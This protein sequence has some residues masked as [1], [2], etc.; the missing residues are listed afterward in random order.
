MHLHGGGGGVRGEYDFGQKSIRLNLL[1]LIIYNIKPNNYR[2]TVLYFFIQSIRNNFC[3]KLL[4][5][6]ECFRIHR[7]RPHTLQC[8]NNAF[9]LNYSM[10][11][12]LRKSAVFFN[13]SNI[14]PEAPF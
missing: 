7:G 10:T 12:T 13:P 6:L 9:C 2:V 14:K 8:L 4:I 11:K 5:Y 3:A 1:N